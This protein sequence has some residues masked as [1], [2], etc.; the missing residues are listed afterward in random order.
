[1]CRGA[2]AARLSAEDRTRSSE[3]RKIAQETRVRTQRSFKFVLGRSP[4]PLLLPLIISQRRFFTGWSDFILIPTSQPRT[5]HTRTNHETNT[6][7]QTRRHTRRRTPAQ[8]KRA[9]RNRKRS[10]HAHTHPHPR[11]LPERSVSHL[12]VHG[13]CTCIGHVGKHYLS[14]H[15]H[16]HP[17]FLSA[18]RRRHRSAL[19][20][21][22]LSQL[23]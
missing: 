14:G 22:A 3:D 10:E 18:E 13:W 21:K 19:G 1:M 2:E 23:R 5:G 7:T 15:R 20:G 9:K 17:A 6:R 16:H 8:T 4:T 11:V 12:D